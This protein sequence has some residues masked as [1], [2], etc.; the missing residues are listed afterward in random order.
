[1]PKPSPYPFV[2]EAFQ[3]NDVIT[4]PMFGHTVVYV[5]GRMVMFFISKEKNPDN[6]VCLATSAEHIPSLKLEFPSLRHLKA[7][8]AKAIDWRLIPADA[9]DFEE[10]VLKA[11]DLICNN[12][13]RIGRLAKSK[14][15]AKSKKV[16]SV[17]K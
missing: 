12:D 16:K 17:K 4:K 11:C 7:Y 1:M 10:A 2:L 6:G 3:E 14:R 13:S 15:I 5:D 8:G 9:D